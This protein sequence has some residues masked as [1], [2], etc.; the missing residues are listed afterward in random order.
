[1]VIAQGSATVAR[2][3][4]TGAHAEEEAVAVSR[5]SFG[6]AHKGRDGGTEVGREP[7]VGSTQTT[8]EVEGATGMRHMKEQGRDGEGERRSSSEAFRHGD[9]KSLSRQGLQARGRSPASGGGR[10]REGSSKL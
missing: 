7:G 6:A 8:L 3:G 9:E 10:R 4:D 5:G 2:F 1:M